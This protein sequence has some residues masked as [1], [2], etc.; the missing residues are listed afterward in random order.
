MAKLRIDRGHPYS[1]T[2]RSARSTLKEQGYRIL[3]DSIDDYYEARSKDLGSSSITD[4]AKGYLGIS[5]FLYYAVC[6]KAPREK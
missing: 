5:E 2:M 6:S 4:R 1:F 3:S